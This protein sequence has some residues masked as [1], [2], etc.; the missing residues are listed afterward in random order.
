MSRNRP[1]CD[2]KVAHRSSIYYKSFES[3]RFPFLC[4]RLRSKDTLWANRDFVGQTICLWW[5]YQCSRWARFGIW[6][7]SS[8]LFWEQA[9]TSKFWCRVL[10]FPWRIPWSKG[11]AIA[12]L[13]LR[14]RSRGWRRTSRRVR[15]LR[16]AM[17]S[18]SRR[19]RLMG[20]MQ[21]CATWF[22]RSERDGPCRE[23]WGTQGSLVWF[24]LSRSRQILKN[25]RCRAD[26]SIWTISLSLSTFVLLRP[27]T[28]L[29]WLQ[30]CSCCAVNQQ[31]QHIQL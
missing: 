31:Y 27:Q 16:F 3:L 25:W 29:E 15:I 14:T 6:N 23:R 10:L 7:W 11:T 22:W 12:F 30:E 20:T 2:L 18:L 24:I 9:E 19:C 4:S 21:R 26:R 8:L 28:W 1:W 13:F 17:E 5:R